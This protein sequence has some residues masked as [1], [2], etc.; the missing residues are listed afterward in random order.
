[1]L[2]IALQILSVLPDEGGEDRI[3]GLRTL[4][5]RWSVVLSNELVLI[6]IIPASLRAK[7]ACHRAAGRLSA[8]VIS[9]TAIGN[10]ADTGARMVSPYRVASDTLPPTWVLPSN[11]RNSA[12]P[13]R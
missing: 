11:W 8:A 12:A 9:T 10:H 2:E 1:M 4:G 3:G 5:R 13:A 6:V 7:A